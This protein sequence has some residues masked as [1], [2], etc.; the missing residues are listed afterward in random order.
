MGRIY[1][2]DFGVRIRVKTGI[3]LTNSTSV[4]LHLYKP[5]GL[6]IE[7]TPIIESPPTAGYLVYETN[8]GDLIPWGLWKLQSFVVFPGSQFYG[9]TAIFRIYKRYD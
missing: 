4:K 9:E 6:R 1:E 8:Q 5:N 3:D 7:L 2:D